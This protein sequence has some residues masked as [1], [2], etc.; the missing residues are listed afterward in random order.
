MSAESCGFHN[1]QLMHPDSEFHQCSNCGRHKCYYRCCREPKD[2]VWWKDETKCVTCLKEC[3][4]HNRNRFGPCRKRTQH[5]IDAD[6]PVF[7][8]DC[9]HPDMTKREH[10]RI[11]GAIMWDCYDCNQ[12]FEVHQ[13]TEEDTTCSHCG[14]DI[15][16][17]CPHTRRYKY[18]CNCYDCYKELP[19]DMDGGMT[20]RRCEIHAPC[21][22]CE[23]EPW[24]HRCSMCDDYICAECVDTNFDMTV[25]R[26]CWENIHGQW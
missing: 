19:C 22:Y 10:T 14:V 4:R 6:E 26:A 3:K 9:K 23:K 17:V 11:T 2:I 1:W 13:F 8:P 24:T 5:Q 20:C 25:C 18:I 15:S 21:G 7:D 12:E 16:E